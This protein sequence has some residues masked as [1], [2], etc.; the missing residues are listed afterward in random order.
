MSQKEKKYETV[1]ILRPDL[2]DDGTKKVNDKIAEILARFGGLLDG[3]KD[4]GKRPL[5]YRIAKHTRGHYFQLNYKGSGTVIDEVER[6]MRLS[7]DVIR[8]LTVKDEGIPPAEAP[9]GTPAPTTNAEVS[10]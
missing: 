4:L 10:V 8:F 9:H 2:T 3:V 7:E 1:Y 5:A 6:W